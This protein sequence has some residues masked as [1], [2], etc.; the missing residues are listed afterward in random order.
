MIDDRTPEEIRQQALAK[1]ESAN[2]CDDYTVYLHER[3]EA[4]EM[5]KLAD[6]LEKQED[7][8]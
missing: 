3:N 7:E 8:T 4:M 5:I 2:H 6:T 1:L